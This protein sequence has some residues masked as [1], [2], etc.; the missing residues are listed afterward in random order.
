MSKKVTP[1]LARHIPDGTL[2]SLRLL[3]WR[4]KGLVSVFD[5]DVLS[6]RVLFVLLCNPSIMYLA[7]PNDQFFKVGSCFYT[8]LPSNL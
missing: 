4:C 1:V 5:G 6:D 7:F 8:D 3:T 2:V